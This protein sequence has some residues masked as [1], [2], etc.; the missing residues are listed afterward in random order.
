MSFKSIPDVVRGFVAL[1]GLR[2]PDRAPGPVD[3]DTRCDRVSPGALKKKAPCPVWSGTTCEPVRFQPLPRRQAVEIYH[4]VRRLERRT[5]HPNHQDGAIG[6]NGLAVLHA[7]LFDFINHATGR[8]EPTRAA[9]ARA[10]N[11]SIRSVDRGLAKLKAS[12]VITWIRQCAVQ[13]ENGIC[14]LKQKANAYFVSAQTQWLG[15]WSRPEAPPPYPEAWG[16]TPPLPDAITLATMARA[17][18][19]SR[20]VQLAALKCDPRDELA[21][22]LAKWG[23]LLITRKGAVSLGCQGDRDT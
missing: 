12:G 9:I 13:I 22:S 1:D 5:R 3:K 23:G 11:V 7:L 18:G 8:L 15:F 2:L 4:D 17:E 20:E 19:A 14:R 6:R 10:A 21:T 16:R